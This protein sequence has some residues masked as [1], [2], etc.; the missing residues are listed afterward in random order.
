MC[1]YARANVHIFF[2][3]VYAK[4]LLDVVVLKINKAQQ[5]KAT[6]LVVG[7]IYDCFSKIMMLEVDFLNVDGCKDS[8]TYTKAKIMSITDLIKLYN[9]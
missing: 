6:K 2:Y 8:L 1:V 9:L 7:G 3:I 5:E 4:A